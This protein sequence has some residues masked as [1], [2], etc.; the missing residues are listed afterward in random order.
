MAILSANKLTLGED[1]PS[2]G[3]GSVASH[4]WEQGERDSSTEVLTE[5]RRG[6][7]AKS[8]KLG[9]TGSARSLADARWLTENH[10]Y[11]VTGRPL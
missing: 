8:L 11:S 9:K 2:R 1:G 10:R 6:N 7:P 3:W 5:S 4:L